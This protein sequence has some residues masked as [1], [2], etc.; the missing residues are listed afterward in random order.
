MKKEIVSVKCFPLCPAGRAGWEAG[1]A[2]SLLPFVPTPARRGVSRQCKQTSPKN[3]FYHCTCRVPLTVIRACG[4]KAILVLGDPRDS[5]PET[6]GLRVP[7]LV[8]SL[9]PLPV[10]WYLIAEPEADHCCLFSYLVW[11]RLDVPF[12]ETF[13]PHPSYLKI[14]NTRSFSNSE[15]SWFW[16]TFRHTVV[17]GEKRYV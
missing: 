16:K 3:H 17:S 12:C 5:D 14:L 9:T 7:S 8:C 11:N 13:R 4:T 1:R 6:R 10:P 2:S 15:S